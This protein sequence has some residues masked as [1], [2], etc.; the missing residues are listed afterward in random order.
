MFVGGTED[1][2]TQTHAQVHLF[3]EGVRSRTPNKMGHLRKGV[4][5]LVAA[6]AAQATQHGTPLPLVLPFVHA[7][8]E[9][10]LPVGQMLPSMGQTVRWCVMP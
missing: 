2:H 9:D 4:G 7:G 1:T 6:A 10:V 3:P 5:R 8:M